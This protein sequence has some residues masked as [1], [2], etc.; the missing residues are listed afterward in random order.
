[1]RRYKITLQLIKKHKGL[2]YVFEKTKLFLKHR[3][4]DKELDPRQG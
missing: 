1:M 4:F 3:H 2:F